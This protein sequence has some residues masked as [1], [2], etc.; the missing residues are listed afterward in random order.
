MPES[1]LTSV[2]S[3]EGKGQGE[4]ERPPTLP[5]YPCRGFV[6]VPCSSPS[7]FLSA[8]RNGN[9]YAVNPSPGAKIPIAALG[10]ISTPLNFVTSW[11]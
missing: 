4:R 10:R 9:E 5:G 7:V 11:G 3:R 6:L 2:G 1:G 8:A